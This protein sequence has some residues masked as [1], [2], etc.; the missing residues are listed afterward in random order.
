M[1]KKL[2]TGLATSLLTVGLNS[3]AH[4]ITITS[5][6]NVADNLASAMLGAGISISNVSYTGHND[7]AGYFSDGGVIGM[8]SGIVLSTGK[9]GNINSSNTDSTVGSEVS[10]LPGNNGMAGDARLTALAGNTTE[11]AAILSFDFA[12]DGGLGG[13]AFFQYVFGSDEYQE[14]VGYYNDVFA[15]YVDGSNVALLPYTSTVVSINSVNAGTNSS[16]Y[17]NNDSFEDPGNSV[18]AAFEFDG[19]TTVL[20]ASLIGLNGGLHHIDIAIADTG[21]QYF[22]SAVFIKGNSFATP[23]PATAMLLGVGLAGLAGVRARRKA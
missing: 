18:N 17:V 23:E 20:S 5:Y 1:K 3:G 16:Y 10:D 6:D 21:D 14:Y 15:F 19:Y 9:M 13:N 12:I 2:L 4:A 11:D 8:D 7:A 22:D